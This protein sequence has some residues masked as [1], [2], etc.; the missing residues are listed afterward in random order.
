DDDA[1]QVVDGPAQ[2]NAV[3]QVDLAGAGQVAA[4]DTD[5][6]RLQRVHDLLERDAVLE[7]PQR[8]D[9]HLVLLLQAAP[10]VDLGDA[11]HGRQGRLDDP[12]LDRAQLVQRLAAAGDGVVENLAQSGRDRPHLRPGDA[13]GEFDGIQTLGDDLAGEVDVGAV[14]EV[15]DHLR[16]TELRDR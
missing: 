8:V 10:A 4:A 15:D 7:Q 12:V 14:A 13:G 9:A 5:V 6:I 11:R 1:A 2:G 16:Q 3:N